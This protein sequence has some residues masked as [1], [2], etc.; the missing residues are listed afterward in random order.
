MGPATSRIAI[1]ASNGIRGHAKAENGVRAACGSTPILRYLLS[2]VNRNR[3]V[4]CVLRTP[5][6]ERGAPVRRRPFGCATGHKKRTGS[7]TLN[8]YFK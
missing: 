7:I 3:S 1:V 8:R 6:H 2:E 5:E 4:P